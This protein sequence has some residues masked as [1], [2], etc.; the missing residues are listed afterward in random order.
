MSIGYYVMNITLT[1]A[2]LIIMCAG[3]IGLGRIVYVSLRGH[4]FIDAAVAGFMLVLGS[5]F[6]VAIVCEVFG[7]GL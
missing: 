7:G 2:I 6:F 3:C 5:A 4:R 1:A